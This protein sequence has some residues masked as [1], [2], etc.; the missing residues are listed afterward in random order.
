MSERILFY[1]GRIHKI[2]DVR[3][4]GDGATMDHMELE[5]ERGI[6]ITSAATSVQYDGHHINLI[7]TPGHVDFTVEVERSLR[8]L[9]GAV[10]VLCSV[11]GVQSQSITVDRQMKR[12]QIPR[13][14]FINKMDRTGANPR[15]VVEQL[16]EKLGADAFMAQIPIGAEDNFRG[17]VD[18]IEM[19]AYTFEGEQ[20]E[21]VVVADVPDDLKDEAED[22]RVNMLDSLSNYSDEV[23]ELLLSE[24]EVS[25]DLIY[26]TMRQAVLNGATPVYMGSAFKNKG[27]QPLLDAIT[28][29]LPSPLDRDIY[30]R[31]PS[32]ES[33][34]IELTP[35]KDK[36]FV[37][38]AF[39][40]VE[41]PFGQLTFMRIYQGSI[42]KGDA[43]VN[44]RSGKKE[45]FSRIVRMHS[46][47][48]EEIDEAYAGDIVA[49][50]GIDCASGDT[51]CSER[52]Y[53][54]LES[55]FVP[56]PVIKIAVT[57][58]NRGDGDKM[59]KA[60][61]RFRK[62]DPTFSVYTD[63]ETNEIL[64]SGMGELHLE[65]YIERIRREYGVEI[66]VGA[67]KVSYR[68]SPTKAV[69]FDYKH[70]KQTGGSGQFAHIKGTL[71]PIASESEDSF[72][73]EEKIVGGRIPKQYI[74]AVEKGF[75]DSL[76]KGPVAEYPVVGTRIELIDGS[77][78]EVDSSEKA[79]YTAAQGC[80][81]EYFKQ[82]S[83]KLLEP[84]MKVEIETP[85]DFQGTVTGDVIRRR[86]VML[87]ND[88]NEGMTV[89]IAEVPL[90]ETFGYATDLRSMTQGQ[91]TFT[92]ELAKYSQTPSNIQEDIIAERKKDELAAAR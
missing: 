85:E 75:R 45:R 38:M 80:F 29:Y 61:Q 48:R 88:T 21:K 13:L 68:E 69:E 32:D 10:L 74:P 70:K 66:E 60:L 39:K 16:R 8:V 65:I 82:A 5:K 92:M 22:A 25:K 23:M 27:V 89:I 71:T 84:I 36:P 62:E 33:K 37:G 51:Y 52:D 54:T 4:G 20:G 79:F 1:T 44:Q 2:E 43:Y 63:E 67:P 47:K 14:A 31:D 19:K 90:A 72:E 64:I 83:P 12:Y 58:L 50:M 9:D 91:G 28:Q 57:P 77:Y 86:G 18:L 30:G 81:R 40:I 49:V 15:R 59:S 55:M 6:T 76:S 73:F 46:E 42:K 3:G 78:H 11:G 24:E 17:V 56:E 53:A 41:D 35:D 26:K 34:K 7:D 87:S